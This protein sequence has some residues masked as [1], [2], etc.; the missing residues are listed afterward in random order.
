MIN[1][2]PD[3]NTLREVLETKLSSASVK[4]LCR[5]NGIFLFSQAS[6]DLLDTASL[7]FWGFHDINR[8]SQNIDDSKNYKKSIRY[9]LTT[10]KTNETLMDSFGTYI[11]DKR[12]TQR[13]DARVKIVEI[14]NVQ[15]SNKPA[16][17]ITIQYLK[18]QPGRVHLLSDVERQ[19]AIIVMSGIKGSLIFDVIH[20]DSSDIKIANDILGDY[21]MANSNIEARQVSLKALIIKNKVALFDKLF[22]YKHKDWIREEIKSIEVERDAE[23]EDD[24]EEKVE[25]DLLQGINSALLK[26]SGLRTNSFVQKCLD[27]GYYFG[28]TSIKYGHKREAIKIILNISFKSK[29]KFAEIAISNSYEIED[30][31][32]VRKV[33]PISEQKEILRYFHSILISIFYNLVETQKV[34]TKAPQKKH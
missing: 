20:N 34:P 32:E 5:S 21:R 12:H 25:E 22:S 2:Y 7:I 8:L 4:E 6:S 19:F 10:K 1:Y 14:R 16:K 3:K 17:E 30:S 28:Q 27:Q 18:R 15:L 29:E 33:L 31:K 9:E 26:G 23:L 24:D 11:N 13:D